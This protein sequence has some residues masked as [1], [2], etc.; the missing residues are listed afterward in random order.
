MWDYTFGPGKLPEV[1]W[2]KPYLVEKVMGK[3]PLKVRWF[4]GELNEVTTATNP[5]RYAFV[6]EGT[7]PKGVHIRRAATLYCRPKDWFGWSETPKANLSW[8]HNRNIDRTAWDEHEEVIASYAG[9]IVH[10]SIL[11]QREGAV[12]MSYLHGM[13]ST[14]KT[15]ALTD[16]PVIRDHESSP[17]LF[18]R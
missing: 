9:K 14:G 6:A 5:G 1:D 15:P 17:G 18:G 3:F 16:T 7:T 10:L 4:D 12:L 11:G 2:K 8:L 13:E